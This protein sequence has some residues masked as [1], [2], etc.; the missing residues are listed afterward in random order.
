[1]DTRLEDLIR[2]YL[3][4]RIDIKHFTDSFT[5]IF[6]QETDYD[7]LGEEKYALF[8]ELQTI[9]ARYSPYQDEIEKYKAHF[10]EEQVLKKTQ[11]VAEKLSISN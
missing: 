3:G 7:S 2:D 9:A 1:M 10:S 6:G 8:N 11:E 5:I 4:N